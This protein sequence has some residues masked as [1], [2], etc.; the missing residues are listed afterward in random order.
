MQ[1]SDEER[2]ACAVNQLVKG[3][4]Y[5]WD[6]VAQTEDVMTMTW[7]QLLTVHN[8]KYLGEAV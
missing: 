2:V 1:L 7:A 6:L 3:A 4:S 5:C 8:E